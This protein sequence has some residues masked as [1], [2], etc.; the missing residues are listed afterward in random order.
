[1]LLSDKPPPHIQT[2][3]FKK[4]VKKPTT[5]RLL[6]HKINFYKGRRDLIL[7]YYSPVVITKD[8]ARVARP[9]I[10]N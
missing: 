4:K 3:T 5:K 6:Q 2:N 7:F 8:A 10:K 1:M 9:E